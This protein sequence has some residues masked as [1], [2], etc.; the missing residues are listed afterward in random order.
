MKRIAPIFMASLLIACGGSDEIEEEA[1]TSTEEA[2]STSTEAESPE[3]T[4]VRL[5]AST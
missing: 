3:T 1:S 4:A 5:G 2:A